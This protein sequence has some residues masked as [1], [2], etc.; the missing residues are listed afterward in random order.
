MLQL[1]YRR[2]G[3][4]ILHCLNSFPVSI[5]LPCL[6]LYCE[7]WREQV[8][9]GSWV[10]VLWA[11]THH[12]CM[13]RAVSNS[14]LGYDICTS[15]MAA[16]SSGVECH[17][18]GESR[19]LSFMGE[20]FGAGWKGGSSHGHTVR[21]VSHELLPGIPLHV[22]CTHWKPQSCSCESLTPS[23]ELPELL[24]EPNSWRLHK[25][26]ALPNCTA[27][28]CMEQ[29]LHEVLFS[30]PFSVLGSSFRTGAAWAKN[31][32]NCFYLGFSWK[33]NFVFKYILKDC[34][35]EAVFISH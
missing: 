3:G 15:Q 19:A 34:G 30:F 27:W 9:A 11:V 28:H 8:W 18:L 24:G 22:L 5:S 14:E 2:E 1:K 33:R 13:S 26:Q 6:S 31:R 29:V 10:T 7:Q 32:G 17:S 16:L 21:S 23:Q 35:I 25:Q 20:L 12:L 4:A